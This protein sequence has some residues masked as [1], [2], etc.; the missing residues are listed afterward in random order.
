MIG[1]TT[2]VASRLRGGE[3]QKACV[4]RNDQREAR[5]PVLELTMAARLLWLVVAAIIVPSIVLVS[6]GAA[7][8]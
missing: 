1:P 3:I 5:R 7:T 2:H 4:G 6:V 8:A